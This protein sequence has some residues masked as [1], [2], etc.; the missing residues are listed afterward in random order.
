MYQQEMEKIIGHPPFNNYYMFFSTFLIKENILIEADDI[1]LNIDV[2]E[3]LIYLN[4]Y[5][6]SSISILS[7]ISL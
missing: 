6:N 2:T 5:S 1:Y 4:I 7:K 3:Y